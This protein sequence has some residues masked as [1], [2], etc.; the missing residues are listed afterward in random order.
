MKPVFAVHF[1]L[2]LLFTLIMTSTTPALA[3]DLGLLSP[4]ALAGENSWIILD[5]RPEKNFDQGH[6]PGARPFSWEKL[7]TTDKDGVKYRILP[8]DE[9]AAELGRL[10][11]SE[12]SLVV[13]Y[14][15]A[16][17]SWGGEGWGA[18]VLTWLGHQGPVRILHGGIRAWERAGLPLEK[19]SFKEA[20]PVT[21]RVNLRPEMNSTV[22]ELVEH[23]DQY[24][25]IDVRSTFEWIKGHLPNAVHLSW[26]KFYQGPDRAPLTRDELQKMLAG[27]GVNLD[28]PVVY[29]CT[30]GI[31]SGYTWMVQDLSGLGM[32]IN[33]EGGIEAWDKLR[34]QH[35]TIR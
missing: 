9:L 26:D 12:K 10:G 13:F 6:L 25:I 23:G 29:Y 24:T 2:A 17:T 7:T 35:E 18:W 19:E 22:K 30:G 33:F 32:A 16:D 1:Y 20:A 5:G 11:I 27:H 14:G 4:A 3:A 28:K 15:D 8:P 21:Y 34:R 31:R